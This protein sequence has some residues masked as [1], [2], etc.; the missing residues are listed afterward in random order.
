MLFMYLVIIIHSLGKLINWSG[1][2]LIPLCILL[3]A[4][5]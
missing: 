2:A 1:K 4:L 3:G 5:L